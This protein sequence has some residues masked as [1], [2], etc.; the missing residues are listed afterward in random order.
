MAPLSQHRPW[1]YP[2]GGAQ[3][4]R[5]SQRRRPMR[6]RKIQSTAE[7]T[8]PKGTATKG[9]CAI[10]QRS[11]DAST[12]KRLPLRFRLASSLPYGRRALG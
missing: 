3:P 7:F 12:P 2:P 11:T 8:A 5:R 6:R 9:R 4:S 1:W 10:E